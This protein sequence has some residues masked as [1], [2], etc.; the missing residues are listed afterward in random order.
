MTDIL[1]GG[2]VASKWELLLRQSPHRICTGALTMRTIRSSFAVVEILPI[3][4]FKSPVMTRPTGF[5]S[6]QVAKVPG[7][8]ISFIEVTLQ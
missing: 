5:T 7:F 1:G 2:G 6:G 3:C 4:I 8:T